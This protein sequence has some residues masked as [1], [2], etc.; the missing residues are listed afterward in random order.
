MLA[1]QV[2]RR[3]KTRIDFRKDCYHYGCVTKTKSFPDQTGPSP[4]PL[5]ALKA[6][7]HGALPAV[8]YLKGIPPC[9]PTLWHLQWGTGYHC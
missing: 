5:P 4:G 9:L 2:C 3:Y 7:N 1:G 6:A 8:P